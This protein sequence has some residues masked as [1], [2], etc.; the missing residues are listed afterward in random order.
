MLRSQ[1]EA[2]VI[3]G[4]VTGVDTTRRVVAARETGEFEYDY[5]ILAIGAAYSWFGPDEWAAH[6]TVLKSLDDAERIRLRLLSAFVWAESRS[7]PAEIRRLLA[8]GTVRDVIVS[9]RCLQL[10]RLA[11]L[12][13]AILDL[14]DLV[15][16]RKVQPKRSTCA[17]APSLVDEMLAQHFSGPTSANCC[18]C[19]LCGVSYR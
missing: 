11:F 19:T 18:S 16:G 1:R 13:V 12:I 14:H 17:H 2:T 3:M 9:L 4:D 15:A 6:A 5:L 8:I 7:D 10:T